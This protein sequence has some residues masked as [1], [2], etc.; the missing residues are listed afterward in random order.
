[1]S[2]AQE[3]DF[4]TGTPSQEV[5]G[6]LAGRGNFSGL[7]STHTLHTPQLFLVLLSPPLPAPLQVIAPFLRLDM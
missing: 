5:A 3:A 1:M 6:A 2:E 7:P 4:G